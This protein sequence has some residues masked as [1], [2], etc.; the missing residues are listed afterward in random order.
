M[1]D[2]DD[3]ITA[4]EKARLRAEWEATLTPHDRI[5]IKNYMAALGAIGGLRK[6]RRKVRGDSEYY[7][8]LGAKNQNMEA[9]RA[10]RA[11]KKAERD[12]AK[13]EDKT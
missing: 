1:N 7:K 13:Q 11:R 12:K 4:K 3:D 10:G 8:K 6:G 9:A 2:E 5:E